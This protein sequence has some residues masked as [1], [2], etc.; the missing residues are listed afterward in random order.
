MLVNANSPMLFSSFPDLIH[1]SWLTIGIDEAPNS[2]EN[3]TTISLL[4]DQFAPFSSTF[5]AGGNI[6]INTANGG[7]WY[8]DN[9]DLYT[10]GN[11]GPNQKVLIAQLTTQ[12]EI[13]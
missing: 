10:N 2:L 12:G 3:E 5:A 11:A 1:D 8:I 9:V 4:E 7:A 6:D 13:S